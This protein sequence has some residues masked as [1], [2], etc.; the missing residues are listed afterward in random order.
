MRLFA[1]ELTEGI[2]SVSVPRAVRVGDCG[3]VPQRVILERSLPSVGA[4][5]RYN[6]PVEVILEPGSLAVGGDK[7][8][9]AYLVVLVLCLRTLSVNGGDYST[10][11][12]VGIACT[13]CLDDTAKGIILYIRLVFQCIC[14]FYYKSASIVLVVSGSAVGVGLGNEIARRVILGGIDRAALAPD[15]GDL[16]NAVVLVANGV[17]V[18]V[19]EGLYT[20]VGV[21]GV[22]F[23]IAQR[24]RGGGQE[25]VGLLR[26]VAGASVG[27]QPEK[28]KLDAVNLHPVLFLDLLTI[29]F[30]KQFPHGIYGCY[31]FTSHSCHLRTSSFAGISAASEE[32]SLHISSSISLFVFSQNSRPSAVIITRELPL[33]LVR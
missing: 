17:S 1:Y 24:V 23:G 21:I 5:D 4:V 28:L 11:F 8:E 16:S 3:Y 25:L 15:G 7:L 33:C 27:A 20:A 18:R 13:I 30:L 9:V 10:R 19:G 2:V 12:I 22:L 32:S 29:S 26:V 6:I 14:N 31:S